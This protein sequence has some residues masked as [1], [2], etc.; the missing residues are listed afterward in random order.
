MS[1]TRNKI[2]ELFA[3]VAS[4]L[5]GSWSAQIWSLSILLTVWMIWPAP[6]HFS[7]AVIGSPD[8]DGM[9]HI[10]TLWWMRESI[11]SL[12]TIPFHTTLINYPF[13]IDLYP[14]EPLN[15]LAISAMAWLPLIYASN[16]LA[17]INLTLTGV[18]SG[19]FGRAVS[20]RNE[21]GIAA[22]I[23]V[24]TSAFSYFS[25]HAG[26][27]ELQHMWLLPLGM[28]MWLRLRKR[29]LLK[30]AVL[31]GLSLAGAVLSCFYYGFFLAMAVS[32]LSGITFFAGSKTLRLLGRYTLA[33]ALSSLIALPV[34]SKFSTS[35]GEGEAPDVALMTYILDG[36]HGQPTTDPPSARLELSQLI[37]PRATASNTSADDIAYGGGRYL[38]WPAIFLLLAAVW[39]SPKKATPWLLLALLAVTLAMGSY[40]VGSDG[41]VIITGDG[42]CSEPGVSC[43]QMPF[44]FLNRALGQLAEPLNFPVRFLSLVSISI[45]VF[46]AIF[47]AARIRGRS[48]AGLAIGLALLNAVD[49]RA[50]QLIP[51]PLQSFSPGQYRALVNP[52][53]VGPYLDVSQALRS[54]PETRGASQSAQ[55]SHRQSIQSVPIER[56][57][58]FAEEGQHW[59]AALP[60][61]SKLSNVVITHTAINLSSEFHR[62]DLALLHAQ[63]FKGV[64]LLGSGPNS[65]IPM[66]L[67]ESLQSLFG[68]PVNLDSTSALFEIPQVEHTEAELE[69]WRTEHRAEV[70]EVSGLSGTLNRQLR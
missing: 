4:K 16:A 25:I 15:G 14:I 11:V 34:I 8:A 21:G 24:Q 26:V 35:Y 9:K 54:D 56:V 50:N 31:L 19:Y 67:L 49:V 12:Q 13:G 64:L 62:K 2:P 5:K 60:F 68:A 70:L 46:G 53:I 10:W 52:A 32:L 37:T 27:G 63:G 58:K 47:A 69:E 38:G 51:S 33:A 20:G 17:A 44:L 28:W 29:M 7:D 36:N 43:Y 42:T 48:L 18:C 40:L 59:A 61:M 3:G 57:E 23:L 22:G 45:G 39:L 66:E 6:L 30:D 41:E 65:L 55:M 1:I